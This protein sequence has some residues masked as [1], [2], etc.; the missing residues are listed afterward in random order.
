MKESS[1]F[2]ELLDGQISRITL[3]RP[4]SFN[5]YNLEMA[6]QLQGL[7]ERCARD[8]SISVIILTGSDRAFCSGGDLKEMQAL[9]EREQEPICAFFQEITQHLHL[10]IT[11]MRRMAKPIIGAVNGPAAGAGFSLAMACDVVIA[12][13]EASFVQAYTK[14]GLVPDGGSSFFLPRL[15]GPAR[16]AELM[17]LNRVIGAHEALQLGLVSRVVEREALEG[18]A[19]KI[20]KQLAQGPKIAFGILKR[21]LKSSFERSLEGQLEEERRAIMEASMTGEFRE[22]LRAFLEKRPP[23]FSRAS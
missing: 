17:L 6:I 5:A 18:E 15:L 14:I 12:S 2:M 7:L 10:S 21:L 22:G 19:L 4:E 8:D 13:S 20:A 11:E 9:L 23:E 3:N 16:A 1:V